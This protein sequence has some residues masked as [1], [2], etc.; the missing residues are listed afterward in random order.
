MMAFFFSNYRRDKA[1]HFL[2]IPAAVLSAIAVLGNL[3]IGIRHILPIFPFLIVFASSVVT[4]PFRRPGFFFP[5]LGGLALWHLGSA[6]SIFPS[7][8]AYFNE[9]VGPEKGYEILVDSNLDWGQDLKRLK[10]YMDEKGIERVY[11]GYFGTADL[12]YYGFRYVHLPAFPER[13]LECE[14]KEREGRSD[15]LAVSATNLQAVYLPYKSS[16]EWLKAYR[17]IARIGHSIFVYDIQKDVAA[18]NHLGLLYLKYKMPR[19]ALSE[20]RLAEEMAPKESVIH[21]NIGFTYS[22]LSM[23]TQAATAYKKAL[24]L[25]P[26]NEVARERLKKLRASNAR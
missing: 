13:R 12:C 15:F 25:D 10:R 20:F 5:W 8:V 23:K 3:N 6:L 7:Y 17:P 26:G 4:I 11:L 14:L 19:Q 16:F 24:K 9:F 1:L 21:A 22:L 18:H 2:L